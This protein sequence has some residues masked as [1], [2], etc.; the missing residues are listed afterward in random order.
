M[1]LGTKVTIL[2]PVETTYETMRHV[3][4]KDP[5]NAN[6]EKRRTGAMH[7]KVGADEGAI[8][9]LKAPSPVRL[10]P[11]TGKRSLCCPHY[12]PLVARHTAMN[13]RTPSRF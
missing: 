10:Y 13:T 1:V 2:K 3:M 4:R 11:V 7:S 6:E 12:V 9:A 5:T 8:E